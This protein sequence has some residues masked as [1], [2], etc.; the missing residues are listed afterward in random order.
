[1]SVEVARHARAFYMGRRQLIPGARELLTALRGY[2]V[3][4]IV[5]N[6]TVD[7]QREKLSTFGLTELIDFMVVSEEVGYAKPDI[8]IFQEALTRARC[9]ADRAV[10]LG[11]SWPADIRGALGAGIAAV[12]LNR[13]G[14]VKPEAAEVIEVSSL[15][16]TERVLRVLGF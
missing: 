6:N 10:M 16:P 5:T 13:H 14:K 4:G 9:G 12:W 11:D 7:E 1:M 2:A 8:R 3:V 15:E